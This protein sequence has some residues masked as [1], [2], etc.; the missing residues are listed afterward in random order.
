[1]QE[2]SAKEPGNLVANS[3]FTQHSSDDTLEQ[4]P[5]D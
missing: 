4:I 5:L 3:V 1:L 2:W